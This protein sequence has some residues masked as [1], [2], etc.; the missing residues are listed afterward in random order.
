MAKT[1]TPQQ[2]R[3]MLDDGGEIA[4]LDVREEGVYARDG[5]LLMASNVPLSVLELR[6]RALLPRLATRIVVCDGGEGL[7]QR[8]AAILQSGGYTDVAVLDGGTPAWKAAGF[9]VYTGVYVPSKAFGEYIQHED[10]PPEVTAAELEAWMKSGKDMVLVDSRPLA[11][12]NR[13]SIP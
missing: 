12:F 9:R 7:A 11:E 4:V 1:I 8:A 5:H 13:N 2:L 10:V 3:Q 6:V